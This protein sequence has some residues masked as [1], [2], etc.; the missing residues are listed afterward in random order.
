MKAAKGIVFRVFAEREGRPEQGGSQG[1]GGRASG[2]G[3]HAIMLKD[4]FRFGASAVLGVLACFVVGEA[5]ATTGT[6]VVITNIASATFMS[7]RGSGFSLTYVVTET[8]L[9]MN[10]AMA[11]TKSVSPVV[12]ASGGEATFV[13]SVRNLSAGSSAFNVTITDRLPVNMEYVNPS[14]VGW[15]GISGGSWAAWYSYDNMAWI[16]GEPADGQP[17]PLYIRWILNLIGPNASGLIEFKARV[18]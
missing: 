17:A 15:P 3:R 16:P 5:R 9:V 8:V 12:Q 2:F 6:G 7:P 14:F 4:V 1:L 18:M 11:L 10:P 13:L